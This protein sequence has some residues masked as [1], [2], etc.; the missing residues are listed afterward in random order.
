MEGLPAGKGNWA[1]YLAGA[2][3]GGGGE[4]TVP[5][6]RERDSWEL[7]HAS[8]TPVGRRVVGEIALFIC[9]L[10]CGCGELDVPTI[11]PLWHRAG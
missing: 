8:W 6:S 4:Q 5:P 3:R 2:G 1:L 11:L 9:F 10:T 7:G